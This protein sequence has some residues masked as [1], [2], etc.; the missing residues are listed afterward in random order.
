MDRYFH[1][2]KLQKDAESGWVGG[3]SLQARQSQS[4]VRDAQ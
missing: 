4:L 2:Y 3:W 1:C